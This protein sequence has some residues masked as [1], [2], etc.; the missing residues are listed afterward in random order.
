[1]GGS[2]PAVQGDTRA[3][4]AGDVFRIGVL[5]VVVG[6]PF[7]LG[8]AALYTLR[9]CV[10]A[11][12]EGGEPECSASSVLPN[13]AIFAW[14]MVGWAGVDSL[15]VVDRGVYTSLESDQS[16]G[17]PILLALGGFVVSLLL[18][19]M[20]IAMMTSTFE[21]ESE[22]ASEAFKAYKFQRAI[23]WRQ[24]PHLPPTLYALEHAGLLVGWLLRRIGVV[25]SLPDSGWRAR[26]AFEW[27]RS[28]S[29]VRFGD[30]I[31]APPES[32]HASNKATEAVAVA[33][34]QLLEGWDATT[35]RFSQAR[36]TSMLARRDGMATRDSIRHIVHAHIGASEQRV[37]ER[38][39]ALEERV[40]ER[41]GAL[42]ERVLSFGVSRILGI[43]TLPLRSF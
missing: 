38:I 21:A 24:A 37:G 14:P 23:F 20:L 31:C 13:L 11:S 7:A 27:E 33:R 4:V 26:P 6:V 36:V 8:T 35:W 22:Y 1:M 2:L 39:G 15:N 30:E 40:G 16:V 9:S 42:E 12:R 28:A 34:A 5:L 43:T 10:G 19:N 18:L 17:R 41:I 32:E 25:R 3:A 29:G